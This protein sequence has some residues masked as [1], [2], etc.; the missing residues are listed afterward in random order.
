MIGAW[1]VFSVALVGLGYMSREW[2]RRRFLHHRI[3][4]RRIDRRDWRAYV[5]RRY[6]R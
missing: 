5:E 1:V 3:T 2:V 4:S 6:R